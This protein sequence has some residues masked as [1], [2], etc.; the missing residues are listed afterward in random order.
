MKKRRKQVFS[1]YVAR[2]E[3]VEFKIMTTS[4]AAAE[5]IARNLL[6]AELIYREPKGPEDIDQVIKAIMDPEG[7]YQ[8][9]MEVSQ[10]GS[11]FR[12]S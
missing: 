4:A 5:R 12:G 7:I 10:E 1:T 3:G 9:E 2:A 8:G 6:G 11:I